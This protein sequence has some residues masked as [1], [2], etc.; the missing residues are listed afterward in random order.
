MIARLLVGLVVFWV[1]FDRGSYGVESRS[2]LAIVVWWAIGAGVATGLLPLARVRRRAL[3]PAGMLAAFA[4]FT[5]LS[6][7]WGTGAEGVYA[8]FDRAALYL[9]IFVLA[10]LCAH[11]GAAAVW[12]DGAALGITGIA[13]LALL[14]RLFPSLAGDQEL[15]RVLPATGTRL[16]YPV[17]YWNGLA[18]LVALGAPLLFATAVERTPVALSGVPAIAAA[19]Y[20]TSSR[21]GA[22]TAILGAL[23]F[24][25]LSARRTAAVAAMLVAGAGSAAAVAIL[26]WRHAL[27]DGPLGSTAARG[28]GRS[29]A[30]LLA[31]ACGGTGL[32]WALLAR[33]LPRVPAGAARVALAL[34]V[35]A[36]VA[37]VVLVHP[38]GR[39]HT[40]QQPPGAGGPSR[41][42]F[43]SEHLLSGAG[44]G[45]WQFW[46]AA[47]DEWRAHPLAGHGAGSY[48][49]W[50][51]Q[52][53]SFAYFVRDAHSLYVEVLGEL[54]VVGLALLVGALVGGLAL[55]VRRRESAA[56]VALVVAYL[57]AAGID[58]MWELTA[59][60]AVAVA[61][62]GLAC[63]SGERP[64][65]LPRPAVRAACAGLALAVVLA[66]GVPLGTALETRA[67]QAAARHDD[68][69]AARSAAL[70]AHDL[71][72]WAASPYLQ[73]AL[74]SE[75]TGDTDR[76]RGEI[77]DAIDRNRDDWRLWLVSARLA[78]EAGAVGDAEAALARARS[79]N[80]R[81]PL[82]TGNPA[83]SQGRNAG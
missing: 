48:E 54:G 30:L 4:A 26:V 62:L 83:A 51:A 18:I 40:F 70:A 81:S 56:L 58:W 1:G 57:F 33:R 25:G 65:R 55:V 21:G 66:E 78:T 61:S 34:A 53:G 45:R 64:A 9:G 60:S 28:E 68:L 44:T 32:A 10:L 82:F 50:W 39:L 7:A 75:L 74:V 77:R 20:L 46:S 37:G 49:A 52:H 19:I 6:A 3:V 24:V 67:S 14:S 22:G 79:L 23:V 71:Q 17:G 31:V 2:A 80:P 11:R 8:E 29:A 12:C 42:N 76:A 63:G 73:L 27:V 13:V 69:A 72:P 59:V 15:L 5:L 35:V 43:V 38:V 47:A 36:V 41:A 16:F